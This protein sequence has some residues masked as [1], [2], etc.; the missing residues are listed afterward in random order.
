[1]L[2]INEGVYSVWIK[3][4]PPYM[5]YLFYCLYKSVNVT[6]MWLFKKKIFFKCQGDK[7]VQSVRA[8]S[9]S[10]SGIT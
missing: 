10:V 3:S 6:K 5:F 7:I 1:M 8:S 4:S 9:V 2:R